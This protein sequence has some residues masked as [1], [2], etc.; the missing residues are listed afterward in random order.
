[1]VPSTEQVF[2]PKGT[3]FDAMFLRWEDA[4]PRSASDMLRWRAA[5][6]Q[7]LSPTSHG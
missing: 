6:S 1:M 7:V 5:A 3:A 2:V 4:H